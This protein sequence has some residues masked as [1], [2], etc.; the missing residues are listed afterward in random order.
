MQIDRTSIC[1]HTR[2]CVWD[3]LKRRE[4]DRKASPLQLDG[5]YWGE[6]RQDDGIQIANVMQKLDA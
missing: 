3:G 1:Q 6:K 5:S 2:K 4:H